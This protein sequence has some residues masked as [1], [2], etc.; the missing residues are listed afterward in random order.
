LFFVMAFSLFDSAVYFLASLSCRSA[1][2]VLPAA[3]ARSAARSCRVA[4]SL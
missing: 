4:A 3:L 2:F 1:A